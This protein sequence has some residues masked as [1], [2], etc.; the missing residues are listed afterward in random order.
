MENA[1]KEELCE[2]MDKLLLNSLDLIEQDVRLS[3]DIARLTTEGQ[4]ELAHTRFTKGPNAVSAVQLP[5]EDY[6]PFQALATVQVEE[7]VEDDAD[8]IQHRTLERH[9]VGDAEDGASRIDPSAWFGI[10]R[11]PSLNIAK[12][13]FARSLDTIVERA[14]VRVRL[15]SY[16]NMFELLQKLAFVGLGF[17]TWYLIG[18]LHLMN[19]RGRGRSVRVIA[20]GLP[21]FAATMIA[22]SRTCDYHHHW[23]DVTV[24]SLI[25]IVLSYLC[26]RQYFPAFS[27]RNCH[28]PYAL[29]DATPSSPNRVK[30]AQPQPAGG[31]APNTPAH[32]P[33]HYEARAQDDE[34]EQDSDTETRRLLS[35]S[36]AE[37][38]EAKW[39]Y[40]HTI[41]SPWRT[42][43][44]PAGVPVSSRSFSSSVMKRDTYAISSA[45]GKIRLRVLSS[46]LRTPFTSHQ[47]RTSSGLGRSARCTSALT[48]VDV[49]NPL[50]RHQGSPFGRASSIKSMP[51]MSS[52]RQ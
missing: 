44:A 24:G 14:N 30:R 38:K 48:G 22:I 32:R 17:L 35:S 31:T 39:I 4:M 10:L 40:P 36:P 28:V 2:L 37:Q 3:Q 7:A 52:A 12:E 27:D 13:R 8:P 33:T 26:Y 11:P 45:I 43:P 42:G 29:L 49:S 25:G 18:K 5:T 6:K 16:L 41:T 46:C 34:Q 19:E 47:T 15:S 1:S 20:A 23:Q 50:P 51:V 9:P 21:L